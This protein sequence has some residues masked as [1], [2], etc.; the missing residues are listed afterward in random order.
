MYC[1]LGDEVDSCPDIRCAYFIESV[2]FFVLADVLQPIFLAIIFLHS[3][4]NKIYKNVQLLDPLFQIQSLIT[5]VPVKM[6]IFE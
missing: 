3:Q 2:L 4:R 6:L 5:I 1:F